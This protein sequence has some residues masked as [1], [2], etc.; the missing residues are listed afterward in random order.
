MTE[1]EFVQ[2]LNRLRV[3]RSHG[4]SA[5]AQ[6]ALVLLR[7]SAEALFSVSNGEA[8]QVLER[9][10][11]ALAGCRPSMAV[12]GQLLSLWRRRLE[13]ARPTGISLAQWAAS[14][15]AGLVEESRQAS[16]LA[17][18]QMARCIDAGQTLM[19]HSSSSTLGQLFDRLAE[20]NIRLILSESRPLNEG[21]ALATRLVAAGH[22]LV[23]IT[24]AQMG[25]FIEQADLV[26]VGADSVL[27]DG[28]LVNKAGTRLLALAAQA[29]KVP[30]YCCYERF[31]QCPTSRH[32]L[33]LEQMAVE[34]LGHG[35]LPAVNLRNV[36]FDCTEPALIT[37][38]VTEAG[39]SRT[40]PLWSDH[41]ASSVA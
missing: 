15:A 37:G 31:K 17:A 34:E 39:L 2:Q 13:L 12:I 7:R 41:H 9:R 4:A 30:F 6:Q 16:A 32:E 21:A 38:W 3:D 25:I 14:Q 19:S 40:A 33:V 27:A 8:R 35:S 10:C 22:Q 18:D 26:V 24:E 20:K 11:L 1:D 28:T 23:L 36:Y 29:A 5:L